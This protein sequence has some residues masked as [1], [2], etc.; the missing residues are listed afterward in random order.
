MSEDFLPWKKIAFFR[1]SA[2]RM[3]IARN[4]RNVARLS[5]GVYL[6]AITTTRI[7]GNGGFSTKEQGSTKRTAYIIFSGPCAAVMFQMMGCGAWIM[8]T[9]HISVV[10]ISVEIWRG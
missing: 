4:V 7:S 8:G 2:A 1:V 9:D 5:D 10:I 3:L 6:R